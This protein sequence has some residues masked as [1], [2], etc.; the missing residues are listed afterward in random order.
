LATIGA[1]SF[2]CAETSQA[3]PQA[4]EAA[5]ETSESPDE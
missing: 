3:S 2:A 4:A 5:P 1:I